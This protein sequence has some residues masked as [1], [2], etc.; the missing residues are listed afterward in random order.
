MIGW[1]ETTSETADEMSEHHI[2]VLHRSQ[3]LYFSAW[4]AVNVSDGTSDELPA[5]TVLYG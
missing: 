2:D 1:F 3:N 5:T 4:Y